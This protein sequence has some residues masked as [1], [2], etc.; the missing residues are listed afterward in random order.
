MKPCWPY[1]ATEL[2]DKYGPKITRSIYLIGFCID[3]NV[4][5]KWAILLLHHISVQQ[6]RLYHKLK[7]RLSASHLYRTVDQGMSEL[8]FQRLEQ[9]Q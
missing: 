9:D 2:Q 6:Y 3:E 7:I 1:V 4:P 5:M 8:T